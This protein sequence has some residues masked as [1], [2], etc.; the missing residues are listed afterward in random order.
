[1]CL[2]AHLDQSLAR[3]HL[4][5]LRAR[6]TVDQRNPPATDRGNE[7]FHTPRSFLASAVSSSTLA[8]TSFLSSS[9]ATRSLS[10]DGLDLSV[11]GRAQESPPPLVATEQRGFFSKCWQGL[12][13]S[14]TRESL[15]QLLPPLRDTQLP[16]FDKA[17]FFLHRSQLKCARACLAEHFCIRCVEEKLH[18]RPS[19][20]YFPFRPSRTVFTIEKIRETFV[21]MR[22]SCF[23]S[24]RQ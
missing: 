3:P 17:P 1:M 11:P 8:Q 6:G 12:L 5:P 20:Y 2:C 23:C 22:K 21:S 14:R 24:C 15:K 19:R 10:L 16:T 4:W 9:K 13:K 18:L 7:T